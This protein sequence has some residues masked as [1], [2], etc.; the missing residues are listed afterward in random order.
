MRTGRGKTLF[1]KC[2]RSYKNK[3]PWNQHVKMS[4]KQLREQHKSR[5]DWPLIMNHTAVKPRSLYWT[6]ND[7][8]LTVVTL[9]KH[10][11]RSLSFYFSVCLSVSLSVCLFRLY[12]PQFW[13]QSSDNHI[14]RIR[15]AV[16]WYPKDLFF[17]KLFFPRVIALFS[18]F[19]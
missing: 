15:I 2:T 3:R 7:H 6:A 1:G 13:S 11:L 17:E 14:F 16:A 19:L 8:S 18:D 4:G 10:D 9:K 12:T 5:E